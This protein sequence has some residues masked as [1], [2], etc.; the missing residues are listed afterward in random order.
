MPLKRSGIRDQVCDFNL[1]G[2]A[3]E[4][5][6]MA[7]IS[8]K[9]DKADGGPTGRLFCFDCRSLQVFKMIAKARSQTAPAKSTSQQGRI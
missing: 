8:A 2:I 9:P 3:S 5:S 7:Q 1:N 4:A 6:E